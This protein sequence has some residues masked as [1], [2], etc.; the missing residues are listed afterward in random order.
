MCEKTGLCECPTSEN[1]IE[2]DIP[3]FEVYFY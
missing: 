2:Y 1:T 3:E